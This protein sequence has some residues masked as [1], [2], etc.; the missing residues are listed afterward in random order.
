M[1]SSGYFCLAWSHDMYEVTQFSSVQSLSRVQL[2]ETPWT[3]ACQ[4]SLSITNSQVHSNPCPSSRWCHPTIASSVVPFSSC[5]QCFPTS[6]S[7]QMSQ[8]FASGSQSIG[9]SIS[10]PVLPMEKAMANQYSCLENPMNSM[11]L[12]YFSS[13]QSLSRVGLFATPWIAARQASLSITISRSS[14]KLNVHWVCDAIQPS[15]PLS[16]PSPPAPNPSQLLLY[17]TKKK[18]KKKKNKNYF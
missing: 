15:H 9:V 8:L 18:K 13:V 10:A 14:L 17:T 16:S 11:N 6:G 7:F 5:P 3:A 1:E 4:A 12:I 2:F